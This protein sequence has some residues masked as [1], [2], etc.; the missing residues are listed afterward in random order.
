MHRRGLMD[1]DAA[2]GQSRTLAFSTGHEEHGGHGSGHTG[3]NGGDGTLDKL[4]RVVDA[5]TGID[6]S[7]G[8]IDIDGD[9]LARIGG[10][11]IEQLGLKH[12]AVVSSMGVP[13]KMM[14]SIIKRLNTSIWVTLS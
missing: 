1:H 4:H 6:A 3:A 9:I 2:V 7:A 11:E 8:R 12:V 14:R 13:R 5:E 10:V